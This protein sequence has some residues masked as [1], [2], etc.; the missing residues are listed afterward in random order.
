MAC[1]QGKATVHIDSVV[2]L[3]RQSVSDV[4]SEVICFLTQLRAMLFF[5]EAIRSEYYT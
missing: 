5:E 4:Y 2:D 1:I 3:Y